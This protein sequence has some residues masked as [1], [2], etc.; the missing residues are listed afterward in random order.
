MII[1]EQERMERE[2]APTAGRAL[3]CLRFTSACLTRRKLN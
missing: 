3:P 2:F 1:T